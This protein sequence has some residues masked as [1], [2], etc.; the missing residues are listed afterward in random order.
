M[1]VIILF[2]AM[3]GLSLL[4]TGCSVDCTDIPSNYAYN[5]GYNSGKNKEDK[6]DAEHTW[7]VLRNANHQSD[8]SQCRSEWE[9]GYDDGLAGKKCKCE[10]VKPTH[11]QFKHSN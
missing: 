8:V 3:F 7:T 4:F 2:T 6:L 10:G 5:D 1:K 11:N 9:Q